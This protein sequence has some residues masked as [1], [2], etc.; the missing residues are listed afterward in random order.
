LGVLGHAGELGGGV[1]LVLGGVV[2]SGVDGVVVVGGAVVV[3]VGSC[4]GF[5]GLVGGAV[6]VVVVG[7]TA[8]GS[9]CFVSV[10]GVVVV[11]P[12]VGG[13]GCVDVGW[14]PTGGAGQHH[15]QRHVGGRK[16][17]CADAVAVPSTPVTVIVSAFGRR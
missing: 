2:L 7:P 17:T 14:W 6:G 5:V 16:S 9:D 11:S 1:S 4:T 8:G 13:A 3:V 12:P 15:S 10:G